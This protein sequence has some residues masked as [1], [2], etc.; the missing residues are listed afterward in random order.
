MADKGNKSSS[1]SDQ[2]WDSDRRFKAF[3]DNAGD[4]FFV[5]D[6]DGNILDVNERACEGLGYSR[7]ELLSMTVADVDVQAEALDHK[8]KFWQRLAAGEIVTV[9]GTHR[10]KNG[11][12]FPVE[13]RI[14]LVDWEGRRLFIAL[15]RDISHRRLA[16]EE[17]IKHI[18]FLESMERIDTAIRQATDLENMLRY[19]IDTIF[20]LF[21]CDRAWLLYPC[22]PAAPTYRVPIETTRPEYPGAR[23]LNMDVP[24]DP[25]SARYLREAL[26]AGKPV[27]YGPG[28]DRPI[29]GEGAKQFSVQSQMVMAVHPRIGKPWL[30]GIHQCSQ[31]RVWTQEERVLFNEI[32]R[33]L[34]D[35]LTGW[36]S[37]RDLRESEERF[38]TLVANIPGV[39]YRCKNDA[40]WT[41]QFISDGIEVLCGYPASDF[42]QSQKRTFASI[43]HR[44]DRQRLWETIQD[45]IEKDIPYT[46]E[47]RVLDK[48]GGEH[49]VQ[50]IGRGMKN[51]QGTPQFLDGVIFDITDRKRAQR[52]Q[53]KLQEQLAQS[54]K[55]E[56]IGQ[57]AGG[58]AHDFN[59][60]LTAIMGNTDML[61]MKTPHD[62][63]ERTLVEQIDTA[64]RRAAD[65]TGQLLAF[66][67]KGKLQVCCVDVH[68][69]VHEVVLLLSRSIDKRIEIQQHLKASPSLVMGDPT[70]LQNAILNLGVNARDAMPNGGVLTF[71]S[72]SVQLDENFCYEHADEIAPGEYV[73]LHV[74]DTGV[75]MSAETQKHIFEPFYTTKARGRGTGLGLA[76]VYGCARSHHGLV[77]VFSELE[78]GTTFKLLL[79]VTREKVERV[80][81]AGAEKLV[82]GQGSILIVDD[83]EIIR[84]FAAKALRNL[85]YT[86]N[87]CGDG[88]EALDFFAEHFSEIDLVIL[89]LV[90]PRLSGQ[91]VFSQMKQINPDVRVLLS[92][93]FTQSH[94]ASAMMKEGALG[95]LSKPFHI[96]ELSVE[97]ARHIRSKG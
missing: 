87:T 31:S 25:H 96:A 97:V 54:Q 38:K 22:D 12:T 75:G 26:E 55:M 76:G 77:S 13:V 33:R 91:Q 47:Y 84:N 57:L 39:V 36:L 85:G 83:E 79:P 44:K 60:L 28:C 52:E 48:M 45:C 63:S 66:S 65:L 72:Q 24:M 16:E 41:M 37:L 11:N 8:H 74:T 30:F 49:W 90:M 78:K 2:T 95:F 5:H 15:A 62:S 46:L 61:R 40:D 70:Q 93:G 3:V 89:D 29:R 7:Q 32:G 23:A 81:V 27:T 86:V 43:V 58:V 92:S 20:D 19:V 53:T 42:V 59:N 94:I 51:G 35:G 80:P 68:E 64:S 73:E 50:E 4:A 18:R 56:A 10:R 1:S 17:R 88:V 69:I 82:P 71:G 6:A 34:A 9:E 14:A 21:G 67:R